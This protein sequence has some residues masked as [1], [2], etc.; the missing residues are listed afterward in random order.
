M[1]L[2]LLSDT[3]GKLD[4][5]RRAVEQLRAAGAEALIHCGDLGA[6]EVVE[7][8]AGPPCWFVFG[9]HDGDLAAD[10]E[11]AAREHGATCL[12]WG[13]VCEV[14][15]RR[16]GVVHGHVRADVWRVVAL[17]PAAIFCGHS[18]VAGE[19]VRDGV[20]R[21]NPGALHRANPAT[22]AL[23]ETDTGAVAWQPVD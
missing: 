11:A 4:R 15:G 18:H 9:N 21:I 22:V 6:A 16:Y 5:T 20:R 8:C 12:G 13:G 1:L 19:V 3:H 14:G 2:G 7:L 10:L 23:F 17:E